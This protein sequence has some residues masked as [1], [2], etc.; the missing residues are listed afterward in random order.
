MKY[1]LMVLLTILT[2]QA[3]KVKNDAFACPSIMLLEKAPAYT[4]EN[5]MD[6]NMYAIANNC[7]LLNK[8]SS[9]EAIG[10]NA[11]NSKE[12]YQEVIYKKTGAHLFLKR[13][14]I[15]IEQF[16]KKATLRF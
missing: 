6:L 14:N 13:S 8:K 7:V 16:G 15:I 4:K 3:D 1:L 9:I 2:L 5:Y 10:Y 12:I 11:N